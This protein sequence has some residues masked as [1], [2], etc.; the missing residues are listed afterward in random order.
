VEELILLQEEVPRWRPDVVVV[1]Y[2]WNDLYGAYQAQYARYELREGEL[3]FV[4]PDPPTFDHPAFAD[5]RRRARQR[6]ERYGSFGP[7]QTYLY[8]LVSDRTKILGEKLRAWRD[9]LL[10][11]ADRPVAPLDLEMD[12]EEEEAAWQ[13]SFAL[14]REMAEVARSH[15]ARFLVLVVPDQAQIEPDV[16]VYSVPSYLWE[17]QERVVGFA[18]EAGIPV[19]D[20]L[21][22]MQEVRARTGEPQFL[23]TNRHFNRVGN[24]VAAEIL[25]EELR[26]RGWSEPVPRAQGQPAPGTSTSA[27]SIRAGRSALQAF[28]SVVVEVQTK[29]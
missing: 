6:A 29:S 3:V 2:L 11:A 10:R 25:V 19:L 20:P 4:P 24:R 7:R 1:G 21:P 16:K 26:R 28:G 14:L 8:R 9:D 5:M 17:V 27:T 12:A 13:L 15:G 18:R 23:P 22:R